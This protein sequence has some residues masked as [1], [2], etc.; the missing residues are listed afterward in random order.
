MNN[1]Y[2]VAIIGGGAAGMLAAITIKRDCPEFSV[3]IFEKNKR[4]GKKLA[5]TGN[6]RCNITNSNIDLS[7]Y[8]GDQNII[9]NVLNRFSYKNTVEFFNSIG[10]LIKENEDGR[11]YPYSLQAS[12]VVDALRFECENLDV[13]I[14]TETEVKSIKYNGDYSVCSTSG[15]FSAN[16]VI[17]AFG[18]IAG[19]KSLNTN[20]ASYEMLKNFHSVTKLAPVIVQIKTANSITRS[21]KG[22]K[23]NA[24][25]T[26]GNKSEYGEVLFCDYG[27]SGPPILQLSRFCEIG[28][29]ITL[30]LMP[31]YNE[32]SL[33]KLIDSRFL[34]NRNKE[35]FFTGMLNKRVGQVIYKSC[36]N[37][38]AETLAKAIKNFSFKVTG[39]TGFTNA[40]AT[41]GGLNTDEFNLN[42]S[43][44]KSNGLFACGEA[45]DVDGDCGGYNLQWAFS[46]GF[47]AA[48]SAEEF[49][50][51][52]ICTL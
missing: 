45:L 48:K 51:E 18:G 25:V 22:I 1:K 32:K 7:H 4:L 39:N 37:K 50:K 42:L 26:V 46:S 21:L 10:V 36:N 35:E 24:K 47:V 5:I 14:F 28:K 44:K 12:S 9:S 27:L 17:A 43:S 6:G 2:N 40:Q 16:V 23:I 8:Y 13:D 31:E 15:T 29:N 19:D 34:L 41:S 11:C 20:K 33:I 52:K 38:T 49:L 3:A 30:D